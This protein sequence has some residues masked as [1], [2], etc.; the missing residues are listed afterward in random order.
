M[1][2][3]TPSLAELDVRLTKL[4]RQNRRLKRLGL[5][6]LLIAGSGFLLAQASR[7]PLSAAPGSATPAAFY[8]TLIVHRLE[9][10]DK[11]GKLRGVWGIG[12]Q[13]PL[14]VLSDAAGKPRAV[15]AVGAAGAGVARS[16]EPAWC[17]GSLSRRKLTLK[18]RVREGE[19]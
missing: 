14:L 4:E 1:Y 7:K 11:A 5:L 18:L 13:G 2:T 19:R 8:D 17:A 3:R 15:L 6:C 16:G 10:R 12:D 9:L